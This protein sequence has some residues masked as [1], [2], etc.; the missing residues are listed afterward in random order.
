MLRV[1]SRNAYRHVSDL[2][3]RQIAEY[4][5]CGL[6]YH[7]IVARVGGDPMTVSRVWNRWVQE[8]N[9]KRHAGGQRPLISSSRGDRHVTHI[10]LMNRAPTSQVLSRELGSVFNGVINDEWRDIT[11]SDE[12]RFCLWHQDGRIRVQRHRGERTLA[13]CIRHRHTGPSFGMMI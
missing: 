11:F 6:S 7:S 9:K 2:D 5:K 1:R 13:A 4:R 3:K 8:G 12:S 10:A